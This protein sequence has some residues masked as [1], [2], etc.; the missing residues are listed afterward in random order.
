M[1]VPV[2]VMMVPPALALPVPPLFPA[3]PKAPPPVICDSA[4]VVAVWT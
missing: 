4:A 3:V 1:A 2:A